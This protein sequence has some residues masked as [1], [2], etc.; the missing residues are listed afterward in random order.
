MPRNT[1]RISF[2]STLVQLK[3]N[4]RDVVD[5]TKKRFN[6]TLVQLKVFG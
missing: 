6:S 2:N 5:L 3:V 1:F 4:S